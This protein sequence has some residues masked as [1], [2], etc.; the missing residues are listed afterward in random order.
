MS[1][2]PTLTRVHGLP[3]TRVHGCLLLRVLPPAIAAPRRLLTLLL[4]VLFL[5]VLQ[6]DGMPALRPRKERAMEKLN[7]WWEGSLGVDIENARHWDKR[8]SDIA[9]PET[10]AEK[11][12][13]AYDVLN[14][15]G[16]SFPPS[17]PSSLPA[18]SLLPSPPPQ[19]S[20]FRPFVPSSLLPPSPSPHANLSIPF[21]PCSGMRIDVYATYRPRC[22]R[23]TGRRER[24]AGSTLRTATR[25]QSARRRR[26]AH[27]ASCRQTL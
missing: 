17:L 2:L 27:G 21:L 16:S 6:L 26:W 11:A 18:P 15:P 8:S 3:L 23:W 20:S 13:M 22:L 5:I 7:D 19:P 10:A 4:D 9:D 14:I 1:A 12:K 24:R 25:Y